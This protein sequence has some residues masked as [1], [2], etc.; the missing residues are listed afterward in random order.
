MFTRNALIGLLTAVLTMIFAPAATATISPGLTLEQ[1]AGTLA[2]SSVATGLDINSHATIA[3]SLESLTV[4]LPAGLLINLN[5]NGG[6][7]LVSAAPTPLCQI[8][9]GTVNSAS[10]SS[11]GTTTSASLYLVAPPTPSGV[12]Q[13]LTASSKP[14]DLAGV[15]LVIQGGA[16]ISGTLTL[17]NSPAVALSLAFGSI[18]DSSH[19]KELQLTF[20]SM[21]LPTNCSTVESV[22]VQASSWEGSSGT[23]NAPLAVSGCSSLPYAPRIAATVTKLNA[24]AMVEVQ[25]SQEAGEAASNALEFGE[26]QGVKLNKVLAPC[27]NGETCTVGTVAAT[28][29]LLPAA[30]LANGMLTLAGSINKGNP[31]QAISGT[32]TMSFPPPFEFAVAGPIDIAEKMLSFSGLPD[33]PLSTLNFTFTGIPAGPA[34]TTE[35]EPGT[36]PATVLS[37]DGNPASKISGPVTNVNCP[38][39]GA[40]PKVSGSLRGLA[41]GRPELSVRTS[42]GSG[43]PDI[44]SL[45]VSLPSGLSFGARALGTHRSCKRVNGNK[46]CT[47]SAALKGLSLSGAKL[48]HAR[49]QGGALVVTFAHPTASASLVARGPLLL[50]SKALERKAKRHKTKGL[51]AHVRVTDAKGTATVVQVL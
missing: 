18:P 13:N 39:P 22:T 32:L 49:I 2:G 21:R 1:G 11:G 34:F 45:S 26:P 28:S 43:A 27:F 25:F 15:D 4:G 40:K 29:P 37:Q 46:K 42:R 30:A 36:I 47:T 3:D 48:A 41:S 35:C 44:A 16:T 38:P 19:L 17:T 7:C 8:A 50:E 12:V 31:S 51:A 9:S 20:S 23:A 10:T 5:T 14:L 33:I 6:A 24:G